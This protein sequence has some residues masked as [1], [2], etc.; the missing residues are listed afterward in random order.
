MNEKL[1]GGKKKPE[2]PK[3]ANENRSEIEQMVDE[4]GKLKGADKKPKKNEDRSHA[5]DSESF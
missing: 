5:E 3:P 4:L 2:T 1:E